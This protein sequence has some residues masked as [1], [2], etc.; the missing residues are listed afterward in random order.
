METSHD[1]R[2]EEIRSRL[3]A[4]KDAG[5]NWRIT[6][7]NPYTSSSTIMQEWGSH[8]EKVMQDFLSNITSDVE[9]LLGE[10]SRSD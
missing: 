9:F 5:T 4:F 7:S 10:C 2:L 6:I 3:N 8:P 1:L